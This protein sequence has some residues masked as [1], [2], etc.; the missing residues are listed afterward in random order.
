MLGASNAV[1]TIA[2][3]KQCGITGKPFNI[4]SYALL[5]AMVAVTGL[6]AGKF[7][8][9]LGDAHIYQNHLEQVR[10]QLARALPQLRLNPNVK[11]LFGFRFEDIAIDHYDPHPDIRAPVAV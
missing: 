2:L 11:S 1:S 10:Y 6:K 9:T 5:T 8:R 7:V 4:A 3:P